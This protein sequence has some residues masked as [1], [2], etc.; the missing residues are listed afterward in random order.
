[1]TS[2]FRVR[3]WADDMPPIRNLKGHVD[4]LAHRVLQHLAR[5]AKPDG[6]D[7]YPAIQTL[8]VRLGVD[9]RE[10]RRALESLEKAGLIVDCGESEYG[11]TIWHLQVDDQGPIER[12]QML[13]QERAH[14][15]A[16][17][18]ADRQSRLRSRRRNGEEPVTNAAS[19][20]TSNG[21]DPVT[22][23]R[24]GRYVTART[25]LRNGVSA[26]R[27]DPLEQPQVE[28]PQVEH[29][30]PTPPTEPAPEDLDVT[31][32]N[33][34]KIPTESTA[35]ANKPPVRARLKY[36]YD[37]PFLAA[38][39]AY[40]KVGGKQQAWQAWKNASG[41]ASIETIMAAIPHYLASVDDPR[42]TKHMATWL[43]ND[44]WESASAQPK[45]KGYQGKAGSDLGP[46]ESY[47]LAA[48]RMTIRKQ[49]LVGNGD[50][51]EMSRAW[52]YHW[53]IDW[54]RD[55]TEEQLLATGNTPE[56]VDWLVDA[57][58]HGIDPDLY[59]RFLTEYELDP[60]GS[61]A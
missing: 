48:Q 49:M 51:L 29:L 38:W 12:L 35:A 14:A 6:T 19:A 4:H 1:M 52:Y 5:R 47:E 26:P 59:Q 41:R 32:L 8:A 31:M 13:N 45:K 18:N 44:G 55:F 28:Q 53:N 24:G 17:G 36:D 33:F 27:T 37:E 11:T 15:L 50:T 9:R 30:P 20:V 23:Q 16:Q 46:K 61:D 43:N 7:A 22:S 58:A 60:H 34:N 56:D 25:P 10:V 3:D 2:A 39:D 21:E 54:Q 57:Y 42:Y 40:G